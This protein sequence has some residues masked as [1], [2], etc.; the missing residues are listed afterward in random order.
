MSRR[1]TFCARTIRVIT[2][3]MSEQITGGHF[4]IQLPQNKGVSW[5]IFAVCTPLMPAQDL[6]ILDSQPIMLYYGQ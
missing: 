4:R 2:T 5:D 1:A 6:I 3:P